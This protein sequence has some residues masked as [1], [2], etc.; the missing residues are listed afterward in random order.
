MLSKCGVR[1]ESSLNSE[2][3]KPVNDKG[4]QPWIFIGRS[5][6]ESLAVWPPDAKSRLIGKDPDS[7]KDWGQEKEVIEDKVIGWNQWL[8]RHEFKQT[9][10]D[11]KEQGSLACRSPWGCKKLDTT[12]WLNNNSILT[13]VRWYLIVLIFI[14]PIVNDIE[15]VFMCLL[16]I[17]VSSLE[18]CLFR[19]FIHF[20]VGLF[21]SLLL[22]YMSCLCYIFYNPLP[23]ASF[24]HI[25]SHFEGCLFVLFMFSFAVE[26]V[27]APH[28]STLAWK[29][30]WT[31][32][33]GRLQS[34][35][36]QKVGHDWATSLSLFT[37]MHWRRKWQPTPVFLPGESQEW[38]SLVGCCFWGRTESDTTEAT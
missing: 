10:G 25:F 32:E 15:H 11:S 31:E 35:Q 5:E 28:C 3:L 29:I 19:S 17:S 37:F 4:N 14:S 23:I 1:E 24:A 7:G 34:M 9:L 26:K 13:S 22:S 20:L 38:G 16:A 8:N 12:E 18:K 27:M 30:P 21:L 33:P 6:A 2:E 36:L